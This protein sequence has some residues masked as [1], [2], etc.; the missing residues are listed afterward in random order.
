M[1]AS[2]DDYTQ[3]LRALEAYRKEHVEAAEASLLLAYHYMSCR[4]PDWAVKHL[5]NVEK[6]LPEDELAPHLATLLTGAIEAGANDTTVN[7]NVGAPTSETPAVSLDVPPID[8]AKLIGTWTAKRGGGAQFELTLTDALTFAWN[9]SEGA[10]N[11]RIAGTYLL[12]GN[13]LLLSSNS[14][15]MIGIVTLRPT[16]G[17]NFRLLENPPP[18]PGLDFSK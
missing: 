17:F 15:T 7:R 11:V 4:H 8:E 18:T 3:Q 13:Q 6:M 5:R 9:A 10:R 12:A 16:G 14:G 1:Y 2:Q